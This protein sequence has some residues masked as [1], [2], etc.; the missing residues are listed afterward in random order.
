MIGDSEMAMG[1]PTK[2]IV[3]VS[4]ALAAT[5]IVTGMQSRSNLAAQLKTAQVAQALAEE[6]AL[7]AEFRAER[8]ES[9]V[10]GTL[11]EPA[12]P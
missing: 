3:I 1:G 12:V 4:A 9:A 7:E 5:A 2:W 10:C 8:A 6:K 11:A